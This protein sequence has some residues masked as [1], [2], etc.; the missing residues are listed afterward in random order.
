MLEQLQETRKKLMEGF[1]GLSDQQLNQAPDSGGWSI[2]QVLH[3]LQQIESYFISLVKKALDEPGQKAEER[4]MSKVTDL[5]EKRKSPIEP[6][7]EFK[8]R[9]EL[10][11][12]LNHS[13]GKVI[14]LLNETDPGTLLE[15]S[16][17]HPAFG[18]LSLKQTLEFIGSHELRH[19]GQIEEI[20]QYLRG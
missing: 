18:K 11:S 15:K 1:A 16:I 2:A 4:D 8:S 3:H 10:V 13:R 17:L 19:I 12:R 20:K 14:A 9:E 7:A 5:T 6:S